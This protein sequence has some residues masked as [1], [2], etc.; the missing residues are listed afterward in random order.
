MQNRLKTRQASLRDVEDSIR[1]VWNA[2]IRISSG[3]TKN[4]LFVTISKKIM[5]D[6]FPEEKIKILCY[7][8]SWI[9]YIYC[10]VISNSQDLEAAQVSISR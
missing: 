4:N 10:S 3:E 6:N 1:K 2:S 8:Q 9:N 7:V 5:N